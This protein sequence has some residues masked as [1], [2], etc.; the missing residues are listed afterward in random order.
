VRRIRVLLVEDDPP[1]ADVTIR[2]LEAEG[3][4]VDHAVRGE[5][6]LEAVAEVA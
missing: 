2:S 3:P 1:L 5:Q 6:A 4:V